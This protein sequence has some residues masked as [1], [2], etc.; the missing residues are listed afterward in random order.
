MKHQT[1]SPVRT[2]HTIIFYASVIVTGAM[3]ICL[4][5]LLSDNW[6]LFIITII[7]MT[8]LAGVGYLL[9]R[10]LRDPFY[11][12][13]LLLIFLPFHSLILL[14][15]IG[16]LK[17]PF[18][19]GQAFQA[20]KE[21]LLITLLTLSIFQARG[22]IKDRAIDR[23]FIIFIILHFIYLLLPLEKDFSSIFLGLRNNLIFVIA[24]FTG[25]LIKLNPSK[26]LH[27]NNIL[28]KIAIIAS[29][30]AISEIFI[31]PQDIFHILGFS[32][33]MEGF[34][35]ITLPSEA[36][37]RGL[38]VQ[39]YSEFNINGQWLMLRRAGTIYLNPVVFSFTQLTV[40][41][42]MVS[43]W[44][45]RCWP[46]SK[47]VLILIAL[48]GMIL[49]ITRSALLGLVFAGFVLVAPI[50]IQ[51]RVSKKLFQ[52]IIITASATFATG[53]YF[54]LDQLLLN[55]VQLRDSSSIAHYNAFFENIALLIQQPW[56]YGVGVIGTAAH[57]SNI[58]L[59]G[60]GE[61]WYFQMT[62]QMG[63]LGGILSVLIT[64]YSL[65]A[66]WKSYHR[67]EG[68]LK[69]I[70]LGLL[71]SGVGFAVASNFLH[72]WDYLQISIPYWMLVGVVLRQD[73]ISATI[74]R[75]G[76]S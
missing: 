22:D 25:R 63:I 9:P 56:G 41:P 16:T 15:L 70:A 43:L 40:I 39:F 7:S 19:I 5:A 68:T 59:G 46:N 66:L 3:L 30:V 48:I 17:L 37:F 32:R 13:T 55:T 33:Y 71:A 4:F 61:S 67:L 2:L 12:Q 72:T 1:N 75:K 11:G 57:R 10:I 52:L 36:R 27:L 69:A 21:I 20:W 45:N 64:W 60:G 74:T 73:D 34:I 14:L 23:I 6:G 42:I 58:S 65:H 31:L 62:L 44:L 35:G 76:Q 18:I 38:P 50:I 51:A 29:I 8:G 26:V 24:Y 54:R 28:I 49:G 47:W 53:L